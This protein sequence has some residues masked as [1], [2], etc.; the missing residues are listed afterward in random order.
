MKDSLENDPLWI[1]IRDMDIDGV[2]RVLPFSRRLARDNGWEQEIANRVIDEYKRFLYLLA[3][4][5][6][7]LTPSD[8][9]DQAWHLHLAYSQHYWDVLCGEILGRPL[10]HGPT[11]G[12][13][14]EQAKFEYWYERTLTRYKH[15][16]GK[17]PPS[18]L[19][20][21]PAERF[22]DVEAFQ[23]VN[24]AR[25][26]VFDKQ[27][28][29]AITLVCGIITLICGAF[30]VEV[31]VPL[32]ILG[33]FLLLVAFVTGYQPDDDQGRRD[34]GGGGGGCGGCGGC[35]GG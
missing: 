19:W 33:G 21:S 2:D 10:H 1:R 25:T 18:D 11:E 13:S 31:R 6:E 7:P 17:E 3:T 5:D 23:R 12:G 29:S 32:F 27:I 30:I 8:Q 26:V 35:G 34:G 4:Q 14:D 22:R 20:P 16:F 28:T 9:V 15:V 24:T